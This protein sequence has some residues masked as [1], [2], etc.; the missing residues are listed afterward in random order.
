[1]QLPA[2]GHQGNNTWPLQTAALVWQWGVHKMSQVV[3][4]AQSLHP[5]ER[6]SCMYELEE[7]YKDCGHRLLS[8]L[9]LAFD[10]CHLGVLSWENQ[11]LNL[12][13]RKGAT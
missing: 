5:G 6:G 13:D 1:M 4:K 8:P 2:V 7:S 10:I 3:L 9:R 11:G 12:W